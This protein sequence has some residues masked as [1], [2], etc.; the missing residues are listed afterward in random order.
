MSKCSGF[1][2]GDFTIFGIFWGDITFAAHHN[3]HSL[4]NKRTFLLF[5]FVLFDSPCPVLFYLTLHALCLSSQ[6]SELSIEVLNTRTPLEMDMK[7][8][9]FL[10]NNRWKNQGK[11]KKWNYWALDP[12][13]SPNNSNLT[14]GHTHQHTLVWFFLLIAEMLKN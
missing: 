5:C 9:G 10:S 1:L 13:L 11:A 7:A 6:R 14:T 12:K 3:K 2:F 4:L 8:F